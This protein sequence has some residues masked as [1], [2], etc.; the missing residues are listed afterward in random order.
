MNRLDF[1]HYMFRFALRGAYAA[2]IGQPNDILDVGCGTGRWALEMANLFPQANVIG[3]DIATP[4]VD[5]K[6]ESQHRRTENYVFVEMNVLDGLKFADASF[7]FTHQRLM[8][9][10][11]PA[12]RW[13][14]VV[15]DL[16]RVTRPRGWVELVE[17]Q[18]MD[19][20]PALDKL[21]AW[22]I[23]LTAKRGIDIMIGSKIG[24]LLQNAGLQ[25]VQ[26]YT[27][28]LPIGAYGGSWASWLSKTT[29]R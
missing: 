18:P 19:G 25:N 8:M 15:N 11:I 4:P 28:R 5:E 23:Q 27:L 16:A 10:G 3:A 12:N 2:P 26:F 21:K 22:Q 24:A 13:Q 20:A 7:D 29:S 6:P 9:G 1:Q 17:A 14:G